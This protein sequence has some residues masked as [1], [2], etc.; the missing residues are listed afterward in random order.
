MDIQGS[1]IPDHK[2]LV[3]LS[4]FEKF[5]TLKNLPKM[6]KMLLHSSI[7][8]YFLEF[9]LSCFNSTLLYIYHVPLAWYCYTHIYIYTHILNIWEKYICIALLTQSSSKV[10]WRCFL[11][12]FQRI[13]LTQ[14]LFEDA[15]GE[16]APSERQSKLRRRFQE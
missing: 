11:L 7:L 15:I 6:F 14:N 16:Y 10:K 3:P 5:E 1:Y 9:L 12:S 8:I 4:C 13:C 2:L